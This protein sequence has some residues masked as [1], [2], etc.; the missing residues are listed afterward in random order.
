MLTLE[1]SIKSL[2]TRIDVSGDI[3]NTLKLEVFGDTKQLQDCVGKPIKVTIEIDWS[4]TG[5]NK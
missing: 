1:G 5:E 2:N 4:K 3:V